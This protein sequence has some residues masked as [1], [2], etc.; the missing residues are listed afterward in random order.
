MD[1]REKGDNTLP[2][3][4]GLQSLHL[5]KGCFLTPNTQIQCAEEVMRHVFMGNQHCDLHCFTLWSDIIDSFKINN[6]IGFVILDNAKQCSADVLVMLKNEKMKR[7]ELYSPKWIPY[8]PNHIRRVFIYGGK[9]LTDRVLCDIVVRLPNVSTIEI[10]NG[11]ELTNSSIQ[12]LI[13]KCHYLEHFYINA[14]EQI[15]DVTLL[16]L[17]NASVNLKTVCLKCSS[18]PFRYD[19]FKCLITKQSSILFAFCTVQ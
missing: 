9:W 5:P 3:C 18:L 13:S 16:S 2:K 7:V 14:C 19:A 12:F 1:F 10:E 11:S 6:N 15:T 8:L 4:N 17:A